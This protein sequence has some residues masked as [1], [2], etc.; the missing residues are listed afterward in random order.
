MRPIVYQNVKELSY[1]E[2]LESISNIKN[3]MNNSTDPT[4]VEYS[5]DY[6]QLLVKELDN[7]QKES[8]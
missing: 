4:I 8:T 5:S 2:L 3:V 1:R 6:Y 7:R